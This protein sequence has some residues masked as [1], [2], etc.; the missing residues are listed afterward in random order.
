MRK[1]HIDILVGTQMVAKG[2]DFP[3]IT[4]VGVV[5]ADAA[6]NIPDFRSAERT[7]QL[8]T[9]VAGRAG[10]ADKPGR[11]IIQTRQPDHASLKAAAEHDPDLFASQELD[12]RRELFYPPFSRL[13]NIRLSSNRLDLVEKAAKAAARAIEKARGKIPASCNI[14]VLGPAPA[15]MGRLR[16]RF[17]WQMLI[18]AQDAA[19]LSRL[20]A[21]ARQ[22]LNDALP[23]GVRLSI[24]VD[25]VNMM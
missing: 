12:H 22:G 3:A 19:S 4:L 2:H 20:L 24:D 1:G 14:A 11:V 9:Q 16:G 18:K 10:R 15:P 6:L 5:A 25:P 23:P 17:R 7:F 13:A 21:L 8:I